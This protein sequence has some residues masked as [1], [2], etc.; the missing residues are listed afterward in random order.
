MPSDVYAGAAMML[1]LQ[2]SLRDGDLSSIVMHD[3]ACMPGPRVIKVEAYAQPPTSWDLYP[4]KLVRTTI[5]P[6][7]G[8]LDY[9]IAPFVPE[10]HAWFNPGDDFHF[11]GAQFARFYKGPEVILAR[12]DD[13]SPAA[14]TE[15]PRNT[16]AR[17]SP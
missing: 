15:A 2:K 16:A 12:T 10:M 7:F 4:G 5:R 17:K 14:A 9:L 1:P 13:A 6:D 3:F 8:W 11:V